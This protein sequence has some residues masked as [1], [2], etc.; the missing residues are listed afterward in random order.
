MSEMDIIRGLRDLYNG[1][2]EDY[3]WSFDRAAERRRNRWVTD[4]ESLRKMLIG[5][6]E[7]EGGGKRENAL[8]VARVLDEIGV[9]K[10]TGKGET[11][12]VEW[13]Y[14]LDSIGA[15]A[16]GYRDNLNK[17]GDL[18]AELEEGDDVEASPTIAELKR[19]LANKLGVEPSNIKIVVEA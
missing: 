8:E 19:I 16:C 10:L 14:R 9:G 11:R 4:I 3:P 7:P 5:S 12:R 18:D 15:V 6:P 13:C 2:D 17:K 1:E